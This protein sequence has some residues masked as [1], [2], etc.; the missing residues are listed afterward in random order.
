M[1]DERKV[2]LMTRLAI[3]EKKEKYK[4][5]VISKYYKRDYVRYNVLKSLVAATIVYWSILAFYV[6]MEFDSI[7][8]KIND[9]DY[10]EVMYKLLGG[11]IL[12]SLAYFFVASIVYSVRYSLAKPGLIRY[13]SDLRD[14]IE[15]EG[16][17]MHHA[18]LIEQGKEQS[19][20]AST[21]V[22]QDAQQSAASAGTK[23]RVS[24]NR[25]Q[26]LQ[27]KA[28]EEERNREQQIIDNARARNERMEA[29]RQEQEKKEQQV[30]ADRRK[31]QERRKQ[32]ERE[33]L[34]RIRKQQQEAMREN[35]TYAGNN[36]SNNEGRN[37]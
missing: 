3:Y 34:E 23:S 31:I 4:D 16:G 6:Y 8:I 1:V 7:L 35:H 27:Q 26:L 33:Q 30:L 29:K 20:E 25:T 9:V 17:P 19:F 37:N 2:R 32:L 15:L 22:A 28:A 18:R 11:Y 10:F 13:N 24:V 14:L 12:F 36:M 21:G 5:L